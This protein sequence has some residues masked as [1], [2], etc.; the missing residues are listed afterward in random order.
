MVMIIMMMM[1]VVVMVVVVLVFR[2]QKCSS[3]HFDSEALLLEKKQ[4]RNEQM[5]IELDNKL[6]TNT[7]R[8]K[9]ATNEMC[10]M[11]YIYIRVLH[12]YVRSWLVMMMISTA[13]IAVSMCV[14]FGIFV[15]N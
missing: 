11:L 7:I 4:T 12:S 8:A 1:L 13:L 9:Q 15:N 3:Y 10:N 2:K 6:R 5:I 14:L